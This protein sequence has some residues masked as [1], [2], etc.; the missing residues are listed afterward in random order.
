M[1]CTEGKA[2]LEGIADTEHHRYGPE[3]EKSHN[4]DGC[5]RVG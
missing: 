5:F 2:S 3:P 1:L 4:P